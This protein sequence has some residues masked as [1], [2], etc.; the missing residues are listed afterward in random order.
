MSSGTHH[1]ALGQAIGPALPD[2]RPPPPPSLQALHGR[3]CVVEPLDPERHARALYAANG[4][5]SEQRMWTY[6]ATGPYGS[7]DEYRD[8]LARQV[9]SRDPSFRAFVSQETGEAV[10]IGA[11]LRIDPAAG[12]IEVGHIALSPLLQRSAAA[13]EAMY[14]MMRYAFELGYRRYEWKC[15]SLNEKSRRAAS[16][17]GFSYEGTFR[18]ATVYKG[19]SRDTAWYSVIDSEWPLL[20]AA[21]ERWLDPGNFDASGRQRLGLADVRQALQDGAVL[22]ARQSRPG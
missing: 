5:D 21:F 4:R 16:R 13:T 19:R 17:L 7:F 11:Y 14:L 1:N 15:D 2:W 3:Y 10:G 18:Q 22:A 12:S 6:L 9:T 8:W 20:R